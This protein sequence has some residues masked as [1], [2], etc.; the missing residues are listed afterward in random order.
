MRRHARF[1]TIAGIVL[2]WYVLFLG[3][4]VAS[5]AIDN[6]QSTMVCSADGQIRW[7]STNQDDGQVGAH[8]GM[9]CPLCAGFFLAPPPAHHRSFQL[10]RTHAASTWPMAVWPIVRASAPPLPS[11]GPPTPLLFA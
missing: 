5:A 2:A 6:G 10:P 11:R 7:I 1:R 3:A 8:A 4:S 9:D